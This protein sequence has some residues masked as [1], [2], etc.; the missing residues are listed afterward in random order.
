MPDIRLAVALGAAKLTAMLIRRLGRGGGTAAPGLIAQRLDSRLI[1]KLVMRLPDGVIV[2]AGTNGKT[3]TARM[4]ADMLQASEKTVVH[5]RSGSNLV[6]GVAAALAAQSSV[7]GNPRAS[8]GL[9]ETD[10]A[11]FGEV[12]RLSRPRVIL[13]NNLFRDQLDR[14]GELNTIATQWRAAL[15]RLPATSTVMV[16]VDD[17]TLAE[18]SSGLTAERVGFGLHQSTHRLDA[19]PH[20]ADAAIC[21]RCGN[22]LA[23]DALYLSHLG[24]W[25]CPS[26]GNARPTLDVTGGDIELHGVESLRL[27]ISGPSDRTAANLHV[28]VPGLYNAYN[29]VA[30]VAVARVVGL[31]EAT[32]REAL[33]EFQAAFGR[34][35]RVAYRD[36]SLTLA[37]VKNPVGFNEVLRM[38]TGGGEALTVPT[39]IV[40]NDLAADGRDVSWLWD[41]DFEQLAKGTAPVVTAG[42]RGTDMANRLKYAGLPTERIV[43]LETTLREALEQFVVALPAGGTGYILPTYTAMLDL[44]RILT[45]LGAVEAFWRT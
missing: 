43:S 19:L 40:I 11:A 17:P 37:L 31:E 21:R 12:V 13:L 42:L 14:Y 23:Y 18:I 38:L 41:V 45:D 9:F 34:I 26:C 28:G 39:M 33:G 1:A 8:I 24:E 36:R 4:L 20:G 6:R 2:V 22:E 15:E 35:E 7:W 5:N 10:E 30:A 25:R 44:R 29:A 32:I 3:T 16:N 27:T